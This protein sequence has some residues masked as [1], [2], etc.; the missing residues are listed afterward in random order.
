MGT[1]IMIIISAIILGCSVGALVVGL[2][3]WNSNK[4]GDSK[5]GYH[6]FAKNHMNVISKEKIGTFGEL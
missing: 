3:M 6:N 4:M 2:I 1:I 5:G